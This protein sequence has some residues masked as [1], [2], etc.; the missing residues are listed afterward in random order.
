MTFRLRTEVIFKINKLIIV[1]NQYSY[2]RTAEQNFLAR[3]MGL[4][5]SKVNAC[6]KLTNSKHISFRK[7]LK[8]Q[9]IPTLSSLSYDFDLEQG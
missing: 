7:N 8:C 2:F 6:P 5:F 1:T 9:N 4:I 3:D